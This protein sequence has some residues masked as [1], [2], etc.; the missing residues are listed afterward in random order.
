[1]T[2]T[3]ELG[4]RF[5]ENSPCLHAIPCFVGDAERFSSAPELIR[6]EEQEAIAERLRAALDSV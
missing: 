5:G 3:P 2:G 1:M 6:S 4:S